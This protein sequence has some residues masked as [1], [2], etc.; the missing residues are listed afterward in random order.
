MLSL[1]LSPKYR[2]KPWSIHQ[3]IEEL[4]QL[5]KQVR[6]PSTTTRIPRTLMDYP[7]FKAN[8]LRV[9]LLFGYV[10]FSN[11][12][13]NAFYNHLLQLVCLLHLAENRRIP[14]HNIMIMQSL[15]ESFVVEFPLLY[16]ERHYVQ[17][18][19]SVVHIAATVRDFGPLTHYT[20]FNF[21]DQLGFLTRTC[22]ST[23]RHAQE[24]ISNLQLLQCAYEHLSDSTINTSFKE[25]LLSIAN[26]KQ[27]KDTIRVRAYR[28]TLK[29]N[30]Y[31]EILFPQC[32]LVFFNR[33]QIG[34]LKLSTSPSAADALADDS[35]I[36]FRS[37]NDL[38]MGR[39]QSIFTLIE[40]KVTFLL[41]DYPTA[42]EDFNCFVR[43]DDEFK[44]SSIQSCLKKD[45]TTCLVEPGNVIENVFTTNAL[46]ENAILFAFRTWSIALKSD[47]FNYCF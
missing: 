31:A 3:H 13:P 22:K 2:S 45:S 19:H 47:L 32:Q 27:H 23:R 43:N 14:T 9:L 33:L 37:H 16:T 29:V 10:I 40:T 25:N 28:R 34:N 20:T 15:G 41:V 44:Y 11:I 35:T 7:K 24:M 4:A 30:Q 12:L 36:L 8:E 38:S 39:I 6:L 42:F 18:V 21:E 26:I 46:M 5:F 1:W 17:V